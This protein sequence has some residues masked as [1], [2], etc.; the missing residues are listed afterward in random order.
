M[1][2][3]ISV[4]L[5]LTAITA[6]AQMPAT[7][8]WITNVSTDTV[9][10][11]MKFSK[12]VPIVTGHVYNNQPSFTPD[13]NSFLF[14]SSTDST[15]TDIYQF[16]LKDSGI[17]QLTDSPESEYSPEMYEKDKI[18][19]VRVEENKAQRFCSLNKE[20]DYQANLLVNFNDSVAYYGWIDKDNVALCVLNNGKTE[21]QIFTL[22]NQQYILQMAEKTGRC[23]GRFT[24]GEFF[25][26]V[27]ETDSTGMIL[28]FDMAAQNL[29]EFC[30]LLTGSEDF[31][32]TPDGSVWMGKEGKLFQFDFNKKEW[33][34]LT[35]FSKTLGNFY[36]MAISPDG[37]RLVMVSYHGKKP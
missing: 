10:N 24:A 11:Q 18:S 19:V 22:S 25:F 7:E 16:M 4:F 30:P 34:E 5:L 14:S 13:G 20:D 33:T 17:V 31:V 27:K 36:R 15:Q 28:H 8:L 12:P 32:L 26:V 29:S 21:L 37:K 9:T 2:T 35:D 1:K 3:V 6:G 23:F